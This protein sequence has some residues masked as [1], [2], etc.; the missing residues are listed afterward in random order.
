MLPITSGE[1]ARRL[2]GDGESI[3][4]ASR[5]IAQETVKTL[6]S[7]IVE[8]FKD[9]ALGGSPAESLRVLSAWKPSTDIDGVARSLVLLSAYR[10]EQSSPS[11]GYLFLRLLA[12]ENLRSGGVRQMLESDLSSLLSDVSDETVEN[13]LYESI[14]HAGAA[15]NVS[16]YVGG[17]TH[18]SVDESSSYPVIVSPSFHNARTL[19][20]R[21]I[22]AFDGVI[23]SVGQMNAFLEKC[24]EDR[25]QIL[26][27][28]RAFST[29]V[30]STIFANNQRGVF[31]I[32]P[33]TPG[34]SVEDEFTILDV[35]TVVGQRTL[36]TIAYDN[37]S[38]C[39]D[40]VVENG[41][42]KVH[43]KDTSGREDLLKKLRGEIAQFADPDILKMLHNR[44]SRISTRRVSVCIGE[45]FGDTREI[46]KER[47][48]HGMRCFL[49]SRR[50]G[51]VEIDKKVYPGDSLKI[52]TSTHEAFRQLVRNTGGALV[53][54]KKVE[55]AERRGRKD[56]RA[57]VSHDRQRSSALRRF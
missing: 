56:R 1:I 50:R 40:V 7:S 29:E 51:V 13:L 24:A 23:E 25:S 5:R 32:L 49:V 43:L 41:K 44:I 54:D 42:L 21:R 10:A 14:R 9:R 18:I 48:D 12:G 3:L 11:A 57:R 28:A 16:V 15:G 45:E 30:A 55:M 19:T 4:S 31:D 38:Q 6:G 47:F 53:I 52:A 8:V 26:L 22:V 39:H 17:I 46:V 34:T 33:V 27:I 20:S 2:A 36:T 37:S 35:S